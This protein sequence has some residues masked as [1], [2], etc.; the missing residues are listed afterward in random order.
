MKKLFLFLLLS[1][2]VWAQP[3]NCTITG[4]VYSPT[5]SGLVIASGVVLT[6]EP[7]TATGLLIKNQKFIVT[8]NGSGVVSWASPQGT[9]IKITGPVRGFTSGTTVY[10]PTD[11]SATLQ[12]L[13]SSVAPPTV[14]IAVPSGGGGSISDGDKGDITVSGSGNTWTIDTGAVNSSKILDGTIANADIANSTIDLTTKVTGALPIANGGTGTTTAAN[15]RNALL[16]SKT[17]NAG[18]F[19]RVNGAETDYEVATISGGGDALTTNPLSQF[20]ATTSSQFAGV[21]SDETG[22]GNVV[23]S[24]SPTLVTPV[25]G[26][27][28]SV[29]LTNAT[30]LPISTGVSGLGTGVA[31]A[32]AV[33]VGSAGAFVAFNGALGTPSSATLTNATGL[34][35]STGVSGI[36]PA[37]NGGAGT[38]N[39]ILKANGSGTVSAATSGTDYA[40]ATSGS[41]ILKGNGSGGFSSASAGTDYS[42]P[43]S[44][45]T[46]T[47][48]T[49]DAE[50]TGNSVTIPVKYWLLAAG[51]NGSTAGPIWDLPTS[52]PAVAACVTGTNIQKGVLQFADT[53]GGFSAQ[54]T[55]YLPGDFTGAIDVRLVWTTS[56]TSGNV[57]WSVSTAFTSDGSSATDDPSF[58]TASTV[59]TAVPGTANRVASSSITGITAT[60]AATNSLFHIKVFRDGNDASDTAGATVDLIGVEITLRRTM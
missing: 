29:T 15:A 50:G 60:G 45:D 35:L 10:V 2:P 38:V 34:P 39:G 53:S 22:S 37:A 13:V 41:A 59:T 21:I 47:N 20:A 31:T 30:G 51:C 6:I 55:L 43:S 24:T 27:P 58:N 49:I 19:L 46:Q 26:T 12:S 18:K 11:T 16:P 17:G 48:K 57:K 4:T 56:A 5:S 1:L 23:L 40:P 14:A 25:L 36:L 32:L 42:T 7:V 33:N 52:T 9:Y 44:T 28:S 54:N 8:S 3:S